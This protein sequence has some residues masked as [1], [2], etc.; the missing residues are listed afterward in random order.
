MMSF[1]FELKFEREK[2]VVGA[3]LK[4]VAARLVDYIGSTMHAH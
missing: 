2:E 3:Q 4:V 1:G